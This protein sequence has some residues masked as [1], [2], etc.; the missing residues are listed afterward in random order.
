MRQWPLRDAKSHFSELVERAQRVPQGIT[1]HGKAV[2][3]LVSQSTFERLS[4]SHETL[5]EF[6]QASP[7][8]DADD[9]VFERDKS[10]T[11][12]ARL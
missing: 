3:V 4:P 11:R 7:L 5:A 8:A 10:L 6:M 1:R 12:D 2:A 9:I